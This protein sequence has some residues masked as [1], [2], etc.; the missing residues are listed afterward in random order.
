MNQPTYGP[1][2]AELFADLRGMWQRADP[3]PSDLPGRV[4]FA[5][6]LEQV[7]MDYELLRLVAT[8]Q[9]ELSVR[10]AAT[11]VNT[12]TFSGPSV[13]VMVRVHEAGADMRSID[14][15]LAPTSP[16]SVTVHHPQGSVEAQV[17]ERGR[18]VVSDLPSGLIRLVLAPVDDPQAT[19]FITPTVEI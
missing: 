13:T 9:D 17:D 1:S 3:M 18:F 7:E 4:L 6:E 2:D 5:L 19:P 14:G 11:D 16:L 10:S 12:I 8:T 15:W